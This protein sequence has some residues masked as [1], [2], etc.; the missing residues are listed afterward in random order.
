MANY[1][2]L[3][4]NGIII[5]DTADIKEDVQGE[6]QAAFGMDLSLEDSTPQGRLIDI[7]TNARTAII[8]NNAYIANSINFNLASGITLDAW[9]ANFN[10]TRG[11]ATSSS[12]TATLTGVTGTTI[13]A[14][15]QA[16]TAAGDVF[17]L[18]NNVTIPNG[19]SVTATFLSLEKGAIPCPV[20]S[21]TKII[22]GTLGWETI[23]NTTAA[24]LGVLQESDASYKQR[25]YDSGLFSGM[26]LIEDYEN[27]LMNVPNVQSVYVKDN[28]KNTTETYDTVN[29][30][31]HSVY[32]CVDG[33]NDEDVANALF[34]RKSGGSNWTGIS[35]QSVSVNVI[36]PTYNDTYQVIFNRPNNVEID[37]NIEL[38]VGTSSAPNPEQAVKNAVNDY[39]NSL[40]IGEDVL[41]L[42]VANA[43]VNAVS[44]IKLTTVEI[45][46]H[47]ET[48]ATSNITI[49]INEAAKTELSNI[50][51][52]INE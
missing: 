6:Y 47:G 39:I 2:Y 43:I 34:Y 18:E 29:I 17:Y 51:V 10:L 42:Q 14:G 48:L 35:G 25:F 4:N 26:S 30:L 20:G 31:A 21:L 9:G 11:A 12:V 33:G 7:E 3:D 24:E 5:T 16:S 49:H 22:D 23:N 32:A 8:E 36:D 28:G 27:A 37:A 38:D 40:A 46:E 15:S 52:T 50:T 44:G 45:A 19:G 41:V 1:T 13:S